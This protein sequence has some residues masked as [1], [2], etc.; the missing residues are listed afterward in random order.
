MRK[1]SPPKTSE[2]INS[3]DQNSDMIWAAITIISLPVSALSFTAL[4]IHP[5]VSFIL[6]ACV[7]FVIII[8]EALTRGKI[9]IFQGA[10]KEIFGHQ[11]TA[12]RILVVAGGLLLILQTFLI[13]EIL[14]DPKMDYMMLNII[15]K[16]Q[17]DSDNA[18]LAEIICPIFREISPTKIDELPLILSMEQAA[19]QRLLPNQI[20]G[21]CAILPLEDLPE[22]KEKLDVRFFAYCLPLDNQN[23]KAHEAVMGIINAEFL[24]DDYGFYKSLTWEQDSKSD[25]F[26]IV[27]TDQKNILRLS[28][29]LLE[30]HKK[31][32]Q[33]YAKD[34]FYLDLQ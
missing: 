2:A 11:E 5:A 21:S 22:L 3:L 33:E 17:C 8:I 25:E 16:K 23:T 6:G 14:S 15:A 26:L 32:L 13:I 10:F 24:R 28:N 29:L 1:K 7:T 20:L 34:T 12:F 9:W 31:Q 27:S 30:R 18:P 19:K 4:G